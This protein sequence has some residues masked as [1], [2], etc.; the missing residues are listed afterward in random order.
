MQLAEQNGLIFEVGNFV[1]RSAIEM[2]SDWHAT[3]NEIK[4]AVNISSVQL[5]NAD[6]INQLEHL[7]ELYQ[8]PANL[9]EIELTE[10]CL[11]SDEYL[12]KQTLKRLRD[13]GVTLSLDDFGTGCSSFSY[14]KNY[15]FTS[16]KIDKSFVQNV[17]DNNSDKEIIHSI[18]QIAKKLDLEVTIEGVENLDQERFVLNEGCDFAQGYLYGKPM[19]GEEFKLC[20][21]P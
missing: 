4:I 1:L 10:S 17:T 2:A 15:P 21:T 3:R 8:F 18:V 20:I 19:T 16:L 14:L 6:F 11:I 12:A 13:I 7:L 9:L 5:K